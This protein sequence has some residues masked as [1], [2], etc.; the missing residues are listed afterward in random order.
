M[1]RMFLNFEANQIVSIA[2]FASKQIGKFTC[3]RIW[4]GSKLKQRISSL[5]FKANI[6]RG[7]DKSASL[8]D[9]IA[10]LPAFLPK[11]GKRSDE[12]IKR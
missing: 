4:F 7:K 8:E 12:A 10:A 11:L 5:N 1:K 3:K 6:F 9:E 2:V